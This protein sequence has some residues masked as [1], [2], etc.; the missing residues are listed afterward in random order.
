MAAVSLR[1]IEKI[2]PNA[3]ED[4]PKKK[5]KGEQQ[6]VKKN[7]LKITD[8]GVVAVENFNLEIADKEFIVLVGP[9]GC[10]KSTTLRMVAGSG[11]HY[12]RRALHRREADE[13][14]GTEG[15]GYRHGIPELRTVSAYDGTAEY[16]IP[17]EAE[18]AF[19][20]GNQAEGG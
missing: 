12:K 3:V 13:R 4:K 19:Q 6:E 10:G 15:Q 5:K 17:P 9:S 2:Y 18:K 7:N 14:R 11:R 1:H 16:G 20:R 8:E